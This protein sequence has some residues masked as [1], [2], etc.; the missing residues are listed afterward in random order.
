MKIRS[1]CHD[2]MG[3]FRVTRWRKNAIKHASSK[4][5][6]EV[7]H[8]NEIAQELHP[9]EKLHLELIAIKDIGKQASLF[10]FKVEERIP[11]FRAGQYLTLDFTLGDTKCS[12]PY[13]ICSAPE[14]TLG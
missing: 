4:P 9:S 6:E 10:R 2:L 7:D 3:A 1:K 8:T 5:S 13:S 14:S 12:R 11:Y